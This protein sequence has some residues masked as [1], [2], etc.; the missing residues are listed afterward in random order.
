[1]WSDDFNAVDGSAVDSSKWRHDTGGNGWGNQELEYYSDDPQNSEQRA[2]NLIVTAKRDS[3]SSLSCWYGACQFSSARLL[4]AG[5][6]SAA[7]GR[8]EARIKIPAGKGVWPAFWMLG[9]NIG[10]VNWP[11]CGEIDIMEAIGSEPATL[12]GSL[13]GPGYSG[14]APLTATIQ[15]PN[16]AKLSDDFHTYAVEWAPNSVKFYLDTIL[17][18]TRT[19]A[20]IPA[21]TGWVFNHP[22]FMI[23]NV[24]V[25]GPWPGSPE[26][27]TPFP[28]QM[29]V[30]Y[31]HVYKAN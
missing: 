7:Y 18:Q 8:V 31:V 24:A 30:D 22:F 10:S 27:G 20:D 13:H 23:L 16:G 12:H 4:T 25:G 19:P 28:V 3:S 6:F 26:P 15:L 1:V 14:G 11:N 2:G 9:D 17:Y 29:L 21:G 5:K